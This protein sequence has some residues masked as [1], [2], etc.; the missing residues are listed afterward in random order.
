MRYPTKD[1]LPA[2]GLSGADRIP[3]VLEV[4]ALSSGVYAA[5]FL[6]AAGFLRGMKCCRGGGDLDNGRSGSA[7]DG[8]RS[9][10]M[11]GEMHQPRSADFV[12]EGK[13]TGVDRAL[14]GVDL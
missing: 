11:G 9:V 1:T 8:R 6:H 14:D 3:R 2:T 10:L 7:F 13:E 5:G 12:G 4:F